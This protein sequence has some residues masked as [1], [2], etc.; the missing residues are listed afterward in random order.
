MTGVAEDAVR[1]AIIGT[2]W[3][4]TALH[5]PGL[6]DKQA[7]RVVAVCDPLPGRAR[8]VADDHLIPNAYTDPSELFAADVAEAVIIATPHRTHFDLAVA[9][10]TAGLDVLVEKPLATS[11]AEAFELVALSERLNRHL[12]VGYTYQYAEAAARVQHAV[13]REI[14][15]L[16]QVIAQFSSNAGTLYAAA[17]D[18]NDPEDPSVPHPSAY[19]AAQGGGQAFTQL[20]HV[21]GMVC[22]ATG[23]EIA[24]VQGFTDNRG[25]EVDVDDVACFRF[26]GGGTGVAASTGTSSGDM[27]KHHVRY[28]GTAG[29]V[30]QDLLGGAEIITAAGHESIAHTIAPTY[31][32][33]EPARA[34]VDLV[35]GRG[36]NHS[37]A[38]PAAACAAFVEAFLVAARAGGTVNVPRIPVATV[39]TG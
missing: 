9:A 24:T 13:Q 3:A 4:G 32:V 11:A 5:L 12:A 7:A 18:G 25:L 30:D 27:I 2:G 15:D 36:P 31:R 37:P 23:R 16:V 35:A 29:V 22:W 38:R 17:T 10:L 1:I 19:A 14:G 33:H 28:L 21:M 6:L 26:A 39:S 20:T 34:F 8:R